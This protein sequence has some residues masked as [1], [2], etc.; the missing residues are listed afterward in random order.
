MFLSVQAVTKPVIPNALNTIE[1]EIKTNENSATILFNNI[2]NYSLYRKNIFLDTYEQIASV[3]CTNKLTIT[4]LEQATNY[5]YFL[6]KGDTPSG[7]NL[8]DCISFS[9]LLDCPALVNIEAMSNKVILYWSYSGNANIHYEIYRSTKNGKYKKIAYVSEFDKD[10]FCYIDSDVKQ[11]T[12]YS[13]F[14]KA[15]TTTKPMQSRSSKM[16]SV[17]TAT[18]LGL[19]KDT[20]GNV[21][22]YAYYTAVTAR[23]SQ[24][25][26]LLNSEVCYT[27]DKTGIRMIDDSYCVALGSYYGSKIGQKYYVTFSSG[28]TIKVIL[29]DQKSNRHTDKKHQYAVKNKDIIEFYIDG[30]YKPAEVDG[31]YNVLPEFQGEITSIERINEGSEFL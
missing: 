13:Y 18:R 8:I 11:N 30:R 10:G 22:T 15:I 5:E 3:Y 9:T 26:K 20:K 24:Q 31:N 6:F 28:N 19:P 7:E 4:N 29:C 21:K 27:D 23:S 17:K 2:G 12:S 14:L 16:Y 1:Y 25:Y